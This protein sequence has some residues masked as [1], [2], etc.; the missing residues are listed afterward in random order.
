M[1][2]LSM[3]KVIFSGLIHD[4]RYARQVMPYLKEEYFQSKENR[5]V[6]NLIHDYFSQYND[7]PNVSTLQVDLDKISLDQPTYEDCLELLQEISINQDSKVEWLVTETEKFCQDKSVYNAIMES[8]QILDGK[9]TKKDKGSIIEI[10]QD[11]L[12]VSFDTHI[13]HDF[14]ED[15][16]NRYEFYHRIEEK[17]PFDIEMFNKITRNGFPKKTLNIVLAGTGVGKTLIMCHWASS[18]LMDGYN[19]LYISMEMA[20]ERIAERIDANVTRIPI[21]RLG[22]LGLEAYQ[23]KLKSIGEKTHGKLIIKEYPTASVGSGH[24]RHL[25][26]ELRRKKKFI[27]DIIYIDYLNICTSARLR[28]GGSVN[29]NTYIKAIAE[30]LR[31]LAVEFNVPI[32]S[33]TQTNRS[34]FRSSDFGMEDTSESFGLPQ[35]TDFMI[36]A[37]RT[38]ELDE[39]NQILFKQ[40]KNR[41]SDPLRNKRFVVGVDWSRMTLY[42]CD[43][44]AQDNILPGIEERK[45][46]EEDITFSSDLMSKFERLRA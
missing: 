20:E 8:I 23:A 10:L 33:A 22:E 12:A 35:T 44:S 7:L 26:N 9:N 37:I 30:E 28:L 27:P 41:Y 14:L 24:F 2:N 4:E 21:N 17:I 45:E 36:A 1:S 31:G 32:V 3:E 18:N 25:L 11:A 19:V 42:D 40:L 6:F 39:L 13:G 34:G 29:T 5:T 38:E 43:Q 15:I 16:E 46:E